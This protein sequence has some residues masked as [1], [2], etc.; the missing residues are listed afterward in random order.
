MKIGIVSLGLIGGSLFKCLSRSEY[1]VFAYTRSKETI[2]KAKHWCDN[3]S[4]DINIIKDC[5]IV[6]VA[7]PINKTLEIL[8]K[9]ETI[10]T[11]DTIVLDCASVKGFVMEKKRPYKFIGSHPMAGTEFTGYNASFKELFEGAKWVLTPAGNITEKE[12]NLVKSVINTTGAKTVIT[13]AKD[14]DEAAALISHA[15]LLVAQAIF[16]TAEDNELA[17]TLAS[18][19]F[20]DMTRLA[21]SNLEMAQDM[22]NYNGNNINNALLKLENEINKL[23]QEN[24]IQTFIKIKELRNKMYSPEGKNNYCNK[25]TD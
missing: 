9:L 15:P 10:V 13:N 22:R 16:K 1:D 11:S 7:S 4:D 18:S 3:V 19:G 20:R 5:E 8:D 23:N 25:K 17:L 12:L 6:F 24:N 2:E 14:H 21:L